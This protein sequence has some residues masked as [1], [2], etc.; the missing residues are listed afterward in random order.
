MSTASGREK[1]FN[2]I[3]DGSIKSQS[4]EGSAFSVFLGLGLMEVEV[5]QT[6]DVTSSN[7][8]GHI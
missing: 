3:V 7:F 5:E 2:L 8:T 1:D 4:H 6:G